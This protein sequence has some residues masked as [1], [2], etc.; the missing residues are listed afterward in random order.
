M[1]SLRRGRGKTK[2]YKNNPAY[3]E[4]RVP[5][6]RVSRNWKV[7]NKA[8]GGRKAER[9]AGYTSSSERKGTC[10]VVPTRI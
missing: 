1:G 2:T 3:G 10:R 9:E 5:G 6:R 4:R 7:D 8:G